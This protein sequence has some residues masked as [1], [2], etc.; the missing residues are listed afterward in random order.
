MRQ[1]KMFSDVKREVLLSVKNLNEILE[2]FLA[3][4]YCG[5]INDIKKRVS[6]VKCC[7][8]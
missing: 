4:L 5:G 8:D 6:M 1:S 3:F 7:F 2:E